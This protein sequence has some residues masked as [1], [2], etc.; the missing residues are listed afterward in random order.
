M[1]TLCVCFDKDSKG[2]LE[3]SWLVLALLFNP[4]FADDEVIEP[5]YTYTLDRVS[6]KAESGLEK[7]HMEFKAVVN[8]VNTTM[9]VTGKLQALH[10]QFQPGVEFEQGASNIK[11]IVEDY[12]IQNYCNLNI[13]TYQ[14]IQFQAM[15]RHRLAKDS[16][17]SLPKKFITATYSK[18]RKDSEYRDSYM[19]GKVYC[20]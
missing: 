13:Q 7:D 14:Y 10:D 17:V 5:V 6:V 8:G 2:E 4:V 9:Q 15:Q 19:T 1:H 11:A 16:D 3:M 18:P 20:N 12:L